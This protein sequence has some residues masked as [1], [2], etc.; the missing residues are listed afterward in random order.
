[1]PRESVAASLIPRVDGRP[2]RISCRPGAPEEV[3]EIFAE[4][5]NDAAAILL[6]P[7]PEM[8]EAALIG[9][10]ELARDPR[11]R[12]A[13]RAEESIEITQQAGLTAVIGTG[14]TPQIDK[15]LHLVRQARGKLDLAHDD[16]SSGHGRATCFKAW[17]STLV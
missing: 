4:L 11:L 17:K 7:R 13:L 14:Q 5:P 15:A 1:M 8:A 6:D 10:G 9:V 3:R 2:S 12:H 16:S